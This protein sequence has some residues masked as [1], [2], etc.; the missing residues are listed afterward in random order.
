MLPIFLAAHGNRPYFSWQQTRPQVLPHILVLM[1]SGTGNPGGCFWICAVQYQCAAPVAGN[2]GT[3]CRYSASGTAYPVPAPH[4]YK[5]LSRTASELP[6]HQTIYLAMLQSEDSPDIPVLPVP[7][8]PLCL[9]KA[10]SL[11][12]SSTCCCISRMIGDTSGSLAAFISFFS[13]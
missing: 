10:S 12:S 7:C 6:A 1:D 11:I 4:Y 9:Y 13:F 5:Q 2:I 3:A 8:T